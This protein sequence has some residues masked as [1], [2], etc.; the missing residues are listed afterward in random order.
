M[1]TW[2][3]TLHVQCSADSRKAVCIQ[4]VYHGLNVCRVAAA[5]LQGKDESGK[6]VTDYWKPSLGLLADKDLIGKLKSYD[7]DN[8]PPK[9]VQATAVAHVCI[10]A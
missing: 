6:P 8:I 5:A 4:S 3:I 10:A 7:K 1:H 2:L 9:W